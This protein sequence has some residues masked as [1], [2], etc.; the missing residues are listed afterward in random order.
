METSRLSE[1]A[2]GILAGSRRRETSRQSGYRRGVRDDEGYR[3]LIGRIRA[4]GQELARK[5]LELARQEIAEIVGANL[6]AAAWLAGALVF[7]GLVLVAF[8]FFVVALLALVLPLW[9]AA[10]VAMLIF[11][12]VAGLLAFIGYRKLVL[13]GPE[14]TIAQWKESAEWLRKRLGRPNASS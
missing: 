11:L 7:A 2:P 14:R 3:T 12:L 5:H 1:A 6:R 10:L 4:N 9:A 8:V 13:R